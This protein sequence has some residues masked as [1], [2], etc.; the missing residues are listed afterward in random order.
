MESAPDG[1]PDERVLTW[2]DTTLTRADVEVLRGAH[3]LTGKHLTFWLNVLEY[4]RF[5]GLEGRVRALQPEV[6]S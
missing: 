4:D 2:A 3:W 6:L 5:P 1:A